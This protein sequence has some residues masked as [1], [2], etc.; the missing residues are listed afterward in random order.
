MSIP[1]TIIRA[2]IIASGVEFDSHDVIHTVAHE[3]QRLYVA[4]LAAIDND[5]P[6]QILHSALGRRIKDIC[7][8]LGYTGVASRSLDIF[9]QHSECVRWSRA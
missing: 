8:E 4:E 9:G 6:F 3:N 2:T 1:D 7:G 5:R